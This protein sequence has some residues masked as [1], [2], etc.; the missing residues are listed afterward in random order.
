MNGASNVRST[1]AVRVKGFMKIGELSMRTGISIRMLRYYELEGV[2]A[3]RRS[4][5]GYRDY[6]LTDVRTVKG[7]KLL[8]A[9]GL[10]LNAIKPFIPCLRSDEPTVEPCEELRGILR[11]QIDLADA[12]MESLVKVRAVLAGMLSSM[13][14]ADEGSQ[15]L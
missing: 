5:N 1:T 14:N 7:V 9:A 2:L 4:S 15:D 3:P 6:S 13:N 8:G 12:K 10:T 11:E